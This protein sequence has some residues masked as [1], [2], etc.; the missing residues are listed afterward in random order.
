M[1]V[2]DRIA[3]TLLA[4]L[5]LIGLGAWRQAKATTRRPIEDIDP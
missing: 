1:D 5:T 3:Q 2:P 4:I